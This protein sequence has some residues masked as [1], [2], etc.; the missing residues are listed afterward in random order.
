ML[1]C[2]RGYGCVCVCVCAYMADSKLADG[3][4]AEFRSFDK[5][6]T[7]RRIYLIRLSGEEGPQTG[8]GVSPW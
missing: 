7:R 2:V 3:V 6:V 4:R 1:I 8:G 5:N